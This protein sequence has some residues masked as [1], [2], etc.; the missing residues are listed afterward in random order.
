MRWRG[1]FASEL[2][3]VPGLQLG[4][5]M[6]VEKKA[7]PATTK[8]GI[9][10][11]L[12]DLA[13]LRDEL[14]VQVHLGAADAKETWENLETRWSEVESKMKVVRE[15]SAESMQEIASATQLLLDEIRE[16]Y[17]RVKHAL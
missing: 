10:T 5:N 12:T 2:T 3:L 14:K 9:E 15:I 13:R 1:D 7:N 17:H 6:N 11:Q 16:G 4:A 8:A